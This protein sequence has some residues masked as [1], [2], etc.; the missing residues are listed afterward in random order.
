MSRKI[1]NRYEDL[2][3]EW[4]LSQG[5][6]IIERNW[7][8]R[9]G[10]LDIVAQALNSSSVVQRGEVIVIEVKGRHHA[11]GWTESLISN[12]KKHS[13]MVACIEWLNQV[14]TG[15]IELPQPMT[16]IQ[17]IVLRIVGGQIEIIWNA[18][19]IDMG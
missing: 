9:Q 18:V 14:E 1:G 4:V 3:S 8:C 19:D 2:A 6:E 11:S 5:W 7:C 13:L 17:L 15:G 12:R 10:E 16:G